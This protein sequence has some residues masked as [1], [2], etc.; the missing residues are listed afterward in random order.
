MAQGI[1]IWLVTLVLAYAIIIKANNDATPGD[2]KFLIILFFYH[3]LLAI[4]YY[5]YALFNPSDSTVY[6]HKVVND[7]RG[8]DWE[9]FYGTSTTFIEWLGYPFIKYVDFTYES[10]MAIFSFFGFLGFYFFYFFFRESIKFR[11]RFLGTDLFTLIFF[12]PNFHFWASSFGKGSVIYMGMALFF[13]GLAK[14]KTRIPALLIGG[15]IIYHV[16]PHIMLVVLVSSVLGLI[17]TNKGISLIW[18][19]IFLSGATAALVFIYQDVLTM[20]GFE[21]EDI[22]GQTLDL[23]HRVSD[24]SKATSGVD[25]SSYSLP[26]QVFTF[27]YRPLFFDAP[28]ILGIIVSFENVL[29]VLLTFKIL[30]FRGI[31]FLM[32]GNFLVKTAI[33][34]FITVSIALAQIAANL[35]L[36]MRQKSQV[37]ILLMFVIISFLDEQ[38]FQQWKVFQKNK[39][40]LA[41]QQITKLPG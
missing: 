21:D 25:I 33:L 16:R 12:L 24:L 6:Y 41:R 1:F 10:T 19:L 14:V 17:F 27:L 37:M 20:V 8:D 26:M 3:T 23:T 38:K 11:H 9:S 36:A 7:Y 32:T 2:K 18:K 22:F 35:G 28:G 39:Q 4:T 34:S 5:L 31:Q 29:Y 13:F 15:L 40:R 30:N